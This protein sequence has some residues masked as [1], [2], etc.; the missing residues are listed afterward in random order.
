ML[1]PTIKIMFLYLKILYL[2]HMTTIMDERWWVGGGG[3][4]GAAAAE[5]MT[6]TM[7]Y[8]WETSNTFANF[9][10]RHQ[11]SVN[12]LIIEVKVRDIYYKAPL[13]LTYLNE[14]WDVNKIQ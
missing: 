12:G 5:A 7:K 9:Y 3:S 10:H 11:V 13:I 8:K 4:C 1:G 6:T 2:L 14:N